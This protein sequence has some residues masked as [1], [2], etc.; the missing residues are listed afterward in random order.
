MQTIKFYKEKRDFQKTPE[1][2]GVEEP[3]YNGNNL[4]V[5]HKHDARSLHYDFRI[6]MEGALI[7]WAVPKGP[8][9]NPEDTRLALRTEDHP[10]K[11]ANFEGVIPEGEYGAGTVLIWDRGTYHNIRAGKE[12]DD[13]GISASL[14]QGKIEIYLEGEKLKGGF[15]LIRT[16]NDQPEK[17]ILKKIK[18]EYADA[19]RKPV[20][21]EV[22]SVK[23]GKT[24]EELRN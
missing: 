15:A 13:A 5:I 20:S 6:E 4:F 1:P 11:Y 24:L 19:R 17:W 21:T 3:D 12:K 18:D 16:G 7:S 22:K 2:E 10:L 9:T 8:S 23:S 14:K